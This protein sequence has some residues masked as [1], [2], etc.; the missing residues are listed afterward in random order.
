MFKWS[1]IFTAR[2]DCRPSSFA[3]SEKLIESFAI[4]QFVSSP[5]N[6]TLTFLRTAQLEVGYFPKEK[7]NLC[8]VG[9][10]LI[11]FLNPEC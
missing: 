5:T 6:N 4:S 8:R 7:L 9:E 3:I 1:K 11:Y 2:K 10:V